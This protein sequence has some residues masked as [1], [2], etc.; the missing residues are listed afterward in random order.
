MTAP[1]QLDFPA[2][3]KWMHLTCPTCDHGILI[4]FI[5]DGEALKGVRIHDPCPESLP[6]G[7]REMLTITRGIKKLPYITAWDKAEACP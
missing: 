3:V 7:A 5:K 2:D 1:S 6:D 4:E